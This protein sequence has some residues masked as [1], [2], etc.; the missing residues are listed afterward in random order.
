MESPNLAS[1]FQSSSYFIFIYVNDLP[2]AITDVDVNLYADDTELHYCHSDFRQLECILQCAVTQLFIWLVANKLKLSVPKSS[3]MLIG[4]RQRISGKTLH[5][6]LDSLPLQQVSTVRY[7]GVYIDQHLTWHQHVEYVLRRV[8]GKLYSIN[9]LKPLTPTVLKLL[10]QAHVLPII[11]YC[12]VVWVP[13][14]VGH[15]KRLERLHSRFSSYDS[16]RSSAF[17]LTLVERRRFSYCHTSIQDLKKAITL[18]LTF[19]LQVCFIR[20]KSCR[21]QCPSF[22]C[23]CCAIKLWQTKSILSWHNSVYGTACLPQ[24]PR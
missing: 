23:T 14:N 13:T 12:D 1:G 18:L 8:R 6:S 2:T 21:A 10:Y 3:S 17:N 24:S 16:A 5:L 22:V 15:L 11:D 20:H 7:L 9:R 19:H 4:T